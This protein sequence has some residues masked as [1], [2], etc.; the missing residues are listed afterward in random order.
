LTDLKQDRPFNSE[1]LPSASVL[2][3][4]EESMIGWLG[5]RSEPRVGFRSDVRVIWRGEMDGV[6]ARAVNLSPT[7][8]LV[9]APMPTACPV[10]SPVL[11][12][13]A[14]PGGELRIRGRVAHTRVLAPAKVGMGIAFVDLSSRVAA[15]L[16][17]AIDESE[18]K[19]QPVKLRFAGTSQVLCTH[20]LPTAD[21]FQFTSALPFLRPETEVDITLSPNAEVGTKGW[22]SAVA[23]DRGPHGV[24]HLVID[25]RTVEGALSPTTLDA[26][27]DASAPAA[28]EA[29]EG[30]PSPTTLE[31]PI[32]VD[33]EAEAGALPD[34]VWEAGD[35]NGHGNTPVGFQRVAAEASAPSRSDLIVPARATALAERSPIVTGDGDPDATK[36]VRIRRL[37][38][39]R[40]RL[41]AG[42]RA[43][44]ASALAGIA[45]AAAIRVL[46]SRP[47][48]ASKSPPSDA[49]AGQAS[50]PAANP[51]PT[52]RPILQPISEPIVEPLMAP[53]PGTSEQPTSF[54]VGLVG[55]LAGAHRYL[56][57]APD[58]V[59]FNLPK[60]RATMAYGT[61]NPEVRGLRAVWVRALPGGGT[62]LRFYYTKAGPSPEV[63]LQNDGVRVQ[64]RAT[65]PG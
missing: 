55:S 45:V 46:S 5:R 47:S 63:L 41:R 12:D 53:P 17:R 35:S 60:A 24:P 6:I 20:A 23:V 28:L 11:C 61:Y 43:V 58:G 50:Q 57:R 1:F 44:V 13:V 34:R 25:I 62:H 14:L 19:A 3:E 51:P 33:A 21:G 65:S 59:A 54:K 49:P 38:P 52:I 18:E 27:E 56:L 2:L 31:A 42:G 26:V 30:A 15:E 16:S 36:I 10:G 64:D 29:V 32:S 4:C 22:V 39:P 8:I 9:D 40:K 7:G 37:L 48:V